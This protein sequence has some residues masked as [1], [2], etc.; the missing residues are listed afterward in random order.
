MVVVVIIM[1][2]IIIIAVTIKRTS[3]Q[4]QKLP[5]TEAYDFGYITVLEE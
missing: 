5:K 1:S 2:I 3:R 4:K